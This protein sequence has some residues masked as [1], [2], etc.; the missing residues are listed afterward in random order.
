MKNIYWPYVIACYATSIV[1]LFYLVSSVFDYWVSVSLDGEGNFTGWSLEVIPWN[2]SLLLLIWLQ[3]ASMTR[4]QVKE[5]WARLVPAPIERATYMF[6]SSLVLI[7]VMF[8]WKPI[9]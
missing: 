3:H 5:W 6:F 4:G 1:T 7:I 2:I 8:A 9:G